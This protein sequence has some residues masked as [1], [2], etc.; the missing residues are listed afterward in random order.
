[1]TETFVI[2]SADGTLAR[3]PFAVGCSADVEDGPL[4]VRLLGRDLVLWRSPSGNVIAAPDLCTHSRGILSNGQVRDGCLVCP[5]HGWTFGDAGRCVAKPSNM[6]ITDKAHLRTY[7][8]TERYGLIWVSL[9]TPAARVIDVAWDGD[10]R[11]RRIHTGVSVWRSNPIR[12]IERLL[13]ETDSPLADITAEVPFCVRGTL[14]PEA[15]AQH[16]RLLA[17]TPVDGRTSLVTSVIWTSSGNDDTEITGLAMADL[18]EVK[19]VSEGGGMR[20]PIV[21][22]SDEDNTVLADWKRRLVASVSP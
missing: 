3:Q 9:G 10:K 19:S 12:I 11:Y 6:P 5:K 14:K 18:P 21:E 15:E 16:H 4:A 22:V 13:A 7:P 1:M 2:F 17:C 20:L 8:C